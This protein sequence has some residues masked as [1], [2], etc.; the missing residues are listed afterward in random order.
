[1]SLDGIAQSGGQANGA[2]AVAQRT[3]AIAQARAVQQRFGLGDESRVA[4]RPASQKSREFQTYQDQAEPR[5]QGFESFD[6]SQGQ[7]QSLSAFMAQS[8]AQG[9]GQDGAP[10][11]T[12]ASQRARAGTAAYE[13]AAGAASG[14]NDPLADVLVPGQSF[15]SSGRAIDLA[16]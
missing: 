3:G 5:P 9:E 15:L 8:L 6:P 4:N 16:I 7:S 14:L 11:Q 1:M 2:G 10:S 13:R 12:T